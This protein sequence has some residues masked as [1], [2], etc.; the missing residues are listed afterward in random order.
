MEP[1]DAK[2]CKASNLEKIIMK[3]EKPANLEPKG[4]N[5]SVSP[6][7]NHDSYANNF[8]V[9]STPEIRQPPTE[10]PLSKS[11]PVRKS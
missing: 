11:I 1:A 6:L 5:S 10:L 2:Q 8:N 9:M 3:I 7:S 4:F